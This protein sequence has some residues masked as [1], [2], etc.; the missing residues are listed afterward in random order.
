[1]KVLII[2]VAGISS[3][4]SKSV[5]R[6]LLKCIYYRNDPSEALL[7]KMICGNPE[8]DK[9]IVVGGF[10]YD[11][12]QQYVNRYLYVYL[13]K[14]VMVH[15]EAY[16]KYGS[17]Y[18][19][20]LGMEESFRQ[21][22]DE[23]VFAEGDLYVDAE[24]FNKVYSSDKNVITINREKISANKSVVFYYDI[25]NKIHYI[26]DTNHNA[27]EIEEP[28]TAISNSGQIWKFA[29]KERMKNVFDNIEDGDWKGT[30]LVYIQKYFEDLSEQDYEAVEFTIWINCNTIED[31][32]RMSG[33]VKDD[34]VCRICKGGGYSTIVEKTVP[35]AAEVHNEPSKKIRRYPLHVV[36]C[37]KCGHIQL[38]EAVDA[39]LYD[40]YLYT[41]SYA[42]GFV[43]Y[44][45]NFV[46]EINRVYSEKKQP[47]VLEIGSSNGYLLKRMKNSGWRVLGVEPSDKLVEDSLKQGVDT[48]RG[49][50]G[51]DMTEEIGKR[52]VQPDVIVLRHVLEH[53]DC[54][55]EIITAIK[56]ILGNGRLIIEVPYL[57]R[58]IEEKQF[59]AFFHE[60]LSYFS[61][62]ALYNLLSK[63]GLYIHKV[64]EN[65]LEGGSILISADSD[66]EFR[67]EDNVKKY[68]ENEKELLTEEKIEFF[69]KN[70]ED[71]INSI[72]EIIVQAERNNKSVAAWGAGQRG[73]TLVSF[74]NLQCDSIR[75]VIDVNENYWGK[76]I[77]GT[78]IPIVS[79]DTYKNS[80]VDE[81]IIFATGYADSII[82]E[83]HEYEKLGG[84]FIKI[85]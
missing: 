11:A 72:K 43:E 37:L 17:G 76:Y 50:F 62:T 18:S 45:D 60:H 49:Y 5:G 7:Y 65:D 15:N 64:Y 71:D 66:A 19:L 70:I 13:D 33:K 8:F 28:F 6:S 27:L 38:K 42:K 3:R 26:Y 53:L 56:N 57:K 58:I 48:I 20:Y 52:I 83:N 41:P 73:C 34:F 74:C 30:N 29:D 51:K 75:Y 84:T 14:I 12:L 78:D 39:D 22:A 68:L 59:Y 25:N 40:N 16:E 35:L 10:M 32:E 46:E 61:V 21:N 67:I 85:V 24:S 2:T 80:M 31:F 55:E 79:P 23:V 81:M 69:R 9:Y 82:K 54:L 4:F 77:P 1:M 47:T 63:G 36:R 44:I